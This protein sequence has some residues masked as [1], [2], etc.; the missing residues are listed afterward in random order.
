M[1]IWGVPTIPLLLALRYISYKKN[2]QAVSVLNPETMIEATKVSLKKG[3]RKFIKY[4]VT[5]TKNLTK[6]SKKKTR[7][8]EL[9]IFPLT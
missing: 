9:G 6:F 8:K 3:V 1:Q 7:A 4:C 5:D 2:P